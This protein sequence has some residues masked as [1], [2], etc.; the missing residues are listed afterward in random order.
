MT[1]PLT[2]ALADRVMPSFMAL[3]RHF[4]YGSGLGEVHRETPWQQYYDMG[5][6]RSLGRL[7]SLFASLGVEME[8]LLDLSQARGIAVD[9]NDLL[10]DPEAALPPPKLVGRIPIT[11]L[12]GQ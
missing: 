11:A 4:Y 8:D 3:G 7:S 2:D 9:G 12:T 10:L 1:E 6:P 5:S